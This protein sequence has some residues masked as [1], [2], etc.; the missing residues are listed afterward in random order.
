MSRKNLGLVHVYTGDGKGKTSAAM[1]AMLR[2]VGQG[3]RVF[4]IQFMK[5]GAYTGELIS[6][7]NFLPHVKFIQYG[8]PCIKEQKQMKL[9]GINTP[10]QYFDYVRDD[11]ECGTCRW[12]FV[13]DMKQ[14][15]Y[16]IE[17]MKKAWEVA[18]SGEYDMVILDEV[19]VAVSLGFVKKEELIR[20]IKNKYER[21]E[22]IITGRG[23]PKEIIRLA[24]YATEFKLIRH[25]FDRGVKARRGIE[26]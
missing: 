17:G 12:C 6:A 21:T 11:I 22:L 15:E 26:Y 23:A 1:G 16:C 14:K 10:Y 4:I 5:G 2:A 18:S 3:M 13:N 9:L 24:D 20:L 19:N 25:P 8:K 7:K